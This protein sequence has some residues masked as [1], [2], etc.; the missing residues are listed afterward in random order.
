[1]EAL[2]VLQKTVTVPANIPDPKDMPLARKYKELHD[3][4]RDDLIPYTAMELTTVVAEAA[5]MCRL[6]HGPE[7]FDLTLT[8]VR[9][10]DMALVGI[11]G[12]P[13][14]EMGRQTKANSPFKMTLPC[15]YGNGGEGYF[16]MKDIYTGGAY[17][18]TTARFK[19]GTA[20]KLIGE[21]IALTKEL[22]G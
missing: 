15:C 12:E 9:I 3:A 5:R 1:V 2:Q 14:T 8:G 20:E 16:P 11:P 18:A 17:E 6:E 10:G 7:S 22:H 13:F 19:K 4:G 21:A